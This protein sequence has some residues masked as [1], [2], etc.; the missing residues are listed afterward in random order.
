M[1]DTL[2]ELLDAQSALQVKMPTTHPS[3]LFAFM[4]DAPAYNTEPAA[5]VTEFL[6]W[7]I[8]ALTD[9]LHELLGETGWKPWATKRFVNLEAA[10]GESIDALHFL[11]NIFLVLGMDAEEVR[12]R[13]HAKHAKN[14]ARQEAGYDG[15]STKCPG[16]KRALDDEAVH[17]APQRGRLG[18]DEWID[19]IYCDALGRFFPRPAGTHQE[20]SFE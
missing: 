11:M 10:R 15:V 20:G 13:Y 4:R 14:A 5:L 9:E 6:E 1:T 17:C 16:C 7:N 8:V 18:T 2:Q 19:G 3:D 12:Q